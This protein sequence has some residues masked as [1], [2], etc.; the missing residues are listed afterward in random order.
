MKRAL[1]LLLGLVLL[2]CAP[3]ALGEA[4]GE[5]K[6]LT[7]MVY[8]TGSDLETNFGAA[9]ADLAE[10][11]ASGFDAGRVNVLAMLGGS[12]RWDLGFDASQNTVVELGPRGI[13]AVLRQPAANMGDPDTLSGFLNYAAESYPA[14][15]YALI[16][17]NHGGGPMEGV[18]FDELNDRDR[19]SLAELEQALSA[20]PFDEVNP[21]AWIG[22]DACMMASVETAHICSTHARYM[23]ASQETEPASGW[24]YSFLA[25]AEDAA[26]GADMGRRIIDAYMADGDEKHMLTLSCVD[27]NRLGAVKS[28]MSGL[29]LNLIGQMDEDSFSRLSN[30]RRDAKGF[31]RAATTSDYDLVDLH[32]L[33]GLYAEAAP[34]QAAALQSAVEKAVVYSSGNQKDAHGLS[35]YSPYYNKDFFTDKWLEAYRD[36]DFPFTYLNYMSRYAYYWLGDQLADWS[37]LEGVALPVGE[38]NVQSLEL[39]L[40]EEQLEH[41]ASAK[42][43]ILRDQGVKDGY[44][45]VYEIGGLLPED[46]VLRADYD[47]RGLYVLD[48]NGVPVSDIYPFFLHDEYYLLVAYLEENSTYADIVLSY[49]DEEAEG[50]WMFVNLMCQRDP[51]TDALEVQQVL[52]TPDDPDELST[53]KQYLTT[54]PTDWRYIYF[55]ANNFSYFLTQDDDGRILPYTLWPSEAISIQNNDLIGPDG[56]VIPLSEWRRNAVDQTAAEAGYRMF[57]EVDNTRPWSLQFLKGRY[58]P[59]NLYAQFI[60][61]D[62]QGVESATELIPLYNPAVTDSQDFGLELHRDGDVSMTLEGIDVVN[63]ATNPGLYFRF[64]L[65]NNTERKLSFYALDIA[66]NDTVVDNS[67]SYAQAIEPH[68]SAR[69]SLCLP[70]SDIP[71]LKGDALTRVEFRP[72]MWNSGDAA[73]YYTVADTVY[74]D[75]DLDV[76]ALGIPDASEAELWGETALPEAAFQLVDLEEAA[77]GSLRGLLRALNT[78]DE[79]LEISMAFDSSVTGSASVNHHFLKSSMQAATDLPLPAGYDVYIPFTVN[80]DMR[81]DRLGNATD[82]LFDV[83][84]AFDYWSIAQVEQLGLCCYVNDAFTY[85]SFDLPRPLELR[86]QPGASLPEVSLLDSDGLSLTLRR[87]ERTEDGRLRLLLDA[88]CAADHSL[89]LQAYSA[90]VDGVPASAGLCSEV[91]ATTADFQTDPVVITPEEGTHRMLLELAPWEGTLPGPD[92]GQIA[93]WFRIAD[94]PNVWLYDWQYDWRVCD[95]ATLS[96]AEPVRA[97]DYPLAADALRVKPSL[98]M[99]PLDVDALMGAAAALPEGAADQAVTLGLDLTE[100]QS[101]NIWDVRAYLFLLLPEGG[102]QLCGALSGPRLDEAGNL[103]LDF[104]GLLPALKGAERPLSCFY[105][106]M[107]GDPCFFVQ[108]TELWTADPGEADAAIL[109]RLKSVKMTF[110]L[111]EGEAPARST[112]Y[113]VDD[114]RPF[115]RED[116][117]AAVGYPPVFDLSPE[118]EEPLPSFDDLVLL[119]YGAETVPLAPGQPLFELRPAAGCGLLAFFDITE[120]D[121][122]RYSVMLPYE[123]AVRP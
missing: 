19:L 55:N 89:L 122:T 29:F 75:V 84:D 48:E 9:T 64:L 10:M 93:L 81:L 97:E 99:A 88:C 107:N 101:A 13:R 67:F 16:L 66:L 34:E 18:C 36:L 85:L 83:A 121:G 120:T 12:Q 42:V 70:A 4:A 50:D 115:E 26:D 106:K 74:L 109:L 117:N 44:M 63:A 51:E 77:D 52:T 35:V 31:G 11:T 86:R 65:E 76:S 61:T 78:S 110:P 57:S 98:P 102:C 17:W 80:R 111:P 92:F 69:V 2:L 62:T 22:F 56:E 53:G 30:D 38:D 103:A 105:V 108:D 43:V 94:D 79:T 58:G 72:A 116:A 32:H 113:E 104:C 25:G 1:A 20:S 100:A 46:G 54:D 68:A 96:P 21:L 112:H 119:R 6:V 45:A 47:Y 33:A 8:M 60:V 49:Q 24:N 90:V 73:A 37:S 71:H 82:S 15:S 95:T 91:Y 118:S 14:D 87:L 114:D 40:T 28:A 123:Q 59:Q 39:P 5:E 3:F 23:I 41:F 7:L 27:L